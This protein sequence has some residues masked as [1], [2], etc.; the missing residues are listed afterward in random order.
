MSKEVS[1]GWLCQLVDLGLTV[2]VASL[3]L[4]DAPVCMLDIPALAI[5]CK[6]SGITLEQLSDFQ[7]SLIDR[8]VKDSHF[9][10]NVMSEEKKIIGLEKGGVDLCGSLI[11]LNLGCD[12]KRMNCGNS[13]KFHEPCNIGSKA[14]LCGS[15]ENSS[16]D[17]FMLYFD[18]QILSPEVKLLETLSNAKNFVSP[19][20]F[21]STGEA[22]IA[23]WDGQLCRAL[24]IAVEDS[25]LHVRYVDSGNCETVSWW[26]CYAITADLLFP[27][28][29]TEVRLHGLREA[30]R[31]AWTE[32]ALE[33][34]HDFL[35]YSKLEVKVM[36]SYPSSGQ[37]IDV[38]IVVMVHDMRLNVRELLADEGFICADAENNLYKSSKNEPC[39]S[40]Q[41]DVDQNEN[42]DYVENSNID[43]NNRV[44]ITGFNNFITEDRVQ[45]WSEKQWG[46]VKAVTMFGKLARIDFYDENVAFACANQSN[47][48]LDNC[49]V[50]IYHNTVCERN[51][52]YV[53]GL[54]PNTNRIAIRGIFAQ[55]GEVA[56][57]IGPFSSI[58]AIIVFKLAKDADNVLKKHV[59]QGDKQLTLKR[60]MLFS[61]NHD[62]I[63]LLWEE[64]KSSI[65]KIEG[66][67]IDVSV[68]HIESPDKIWVRYKIYECLARE[69]H[70]TL[71]KLGEKAHSG[72]LEEVL[73]LGSKV[74]CKDN[75]GIW[76][77]GKISEFKDDKVMIQLVDRGCS[78]LFD[79]NSVRILVHSLLREVKPLAELVTLR[80]IEPAGGETWS[81]K[82]LDVLTNCLKKGELI[83]VNHPD[84]VKD[85][86]LVER[87]SKN[88]LDLETVKKTSLSQ[89]LL[90][91]GVALKVNTRSKYLRASN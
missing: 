25:N 41:V 86:L 35:G 42:H 29:A 56:F 84:A 26:E 15:Y 67:E 44:F 19:P 77:R 16:P 83:L 54:Q 48:T 70:E 57:I 49:S 24:V 90:K 61:E 12:S 30:E 87:L 85:L 75:E 21:I 62:S 46:Y 88:P 32:D 14:S 7:H 13:V 51:G 39:N 3:E 71:N 64:C 22:V 9:N 10:L 8:L 28:L 72:R 69:L 65:E 6:L 63:K 11:F 5:P 53:Y 27:P 20:G 55:Y 74:M 76:A 43:H 73:Q 18:E 82:A 89:I 4:A 40:F 52:I 1:G 38:E 31:G 80:G 47:A 34:F 91:K 33:R 45:A 17:S 68:V 58:Q 79:R 81:I 36:N 23:P 37:P 66:S 78:S 50:N 59:M 60:S 2:T